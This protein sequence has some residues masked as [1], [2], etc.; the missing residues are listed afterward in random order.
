MVGA[1]RAAGAEAHPE[2]D[3][4]RAASGAP[5]P[6]PRLAALARRHAL[7]PTAVVMAAGEGRRMRPVT[8]RWPEAGAAG[9]RS[10]RGRDAA[11]RP[12]RRRGRARGRRH[13]ASRRAGRGAAR[14]GGF[15][16]QVEFV[17][18]PTPDGSAD[19]VRR[20][21]AAGARPPLVVTAADTV[22]APG[23]LAWFLDAAEGADG[24]IAVRRSPPPGPGR[25]PAE[26]EDG[27]IRRVL[28]RRG[29]ALGRAALVPDRRAA[30]AP[31]GPP[32]PAVR[33]RG[34]CSSA[35]IDEGLAIGAVEIGKTRDLTTPIDL[36]R[37]N[38]PYLTR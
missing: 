33:A 1:A 10:A 13:R 16:L 5:H 18:Q 35:A 22:F 8:E 2:L 29:R 4:D 23:D 28:A 27:R 36:V 14:G 34:A 11:P 32:G 12:G 31:R 19:T 30:R 21:L 3:P 15:G 7:R 37:E 6:G 26:I 24:A 20:A 25:P 9:R 38:H 17:R